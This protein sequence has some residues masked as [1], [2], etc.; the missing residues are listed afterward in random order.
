MRAWQAGLHSVVVGAVPHGLHREGEVRE[1]HDVTG[2]IGS[3]GT[4]PAQTDRVQGET[5]IRALHTPMTGVP[6]DMPGQGICRA[7]VAVPQGT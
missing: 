3:E 5:L 2:Q 4:V 1:A 7:C 6:L